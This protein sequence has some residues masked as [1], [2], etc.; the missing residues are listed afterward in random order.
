MSV[1]HLPKRWN[2]GEIQHGEAR[3]LA[4]DTGLSP[5]LA[6]LL[7]LRGLDNPAAIERFLRPGLGQLSDPYLLTGMADA[8]ERITLARSRGERVLVFGDYDVDGISATAILVNALKRFGI[9]N[10]SYGMPARLE[11]GYGLSPSHV[12]A[13][14]REGVSLIVTVDNGITAF[15]AAERARK[16]GVGLVVTDHHALDTRLPPA[17]AVINPRREAETYPGYHL[18][19]AGV[20]FKLSCALN[21]T[22]NDLDLAALGTVA[23]MMPLTGENRVIVS[24]GLRH[25]AKHQRTGLKCLAASANFPIEEVT[26][27]RIGFQLGPR[28]NAAGRLMDAEVALRLLLAECPVEGAGLAREL[29]RANEERRAVER[30]IFDEAAAE[31]DAFLSEQQRG[32]VVARSDWHP[33]VIGIVAAKIQSRYRRPVVLIA[34]DE[35]GEGR[36]S[37]RSGPGFDMVEALT[38]CQQHLLKYGGH[39]AAAGLSIRSEQVPHFKRAFEEE[40]LRQI[41]TEPV[42]DEIRVDLIASFSQ[43]DFALLRAIE[44]LEPFGNGNPEPVFATMGVEVIPESIRVLKEHHLK[45]RLRQGDAVFDAIGFDLAPRYYAESLP[46]RIDVAY[47]PQVNTWRGEQSIQLLLRDYRPAT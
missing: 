37:G 22:P 4:A 11:E 29:E 34:L 31:L 36:G 27:Q 42:P 19:G 21:G 28:I 47:T 12:D 9:A 15:D 3:Q 45:M 23:D 32:V 24:L 14:K 20:A 38:R 43:I 7:L 44:T 40:V 33:G 16:T 18:C 26:S 1:T 13:A 6:H 2:I 39:R 8:V 46:H 25:M 35:S 30:A 10:P 5:L 41:G 17:C